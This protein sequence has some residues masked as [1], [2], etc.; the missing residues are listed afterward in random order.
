MSGVFRLAIVN[1]QDSSRE[2]LKHTLAELACVWLESECARY[3][4]F[5]EIV[6]QTR[7]D[8]IIVALDADPDRALRLVEEIG[9]LVSDASILVTSGTADGGLILRALRVGAKEFLTLPI[10]LP[11]FTNA[12]TRISDLD[13]G[14][15]GEKTQRSLTLAV[16]GSSGGVGATSLAVNLG[17]VLA[18]EQENEVALVDLDLALGDT[19]VFLDSMPDYTL[20][21]VALNVARLDLPLLKQSLTR[22]ESGVYLLPRPLAIQDAGIIDPDGLRRVIGLMKAAFSHVIL[23]LSKGYSALDMMALDAAD[24]VFLVTQLDLPGLRNTVR[25]LGCLGEIDGLVDK[26]KI[27]ANR[28]GRGDGQIGF[29]NAEENIGKEF[30][31]KLPNDYRSMIEMRNNGVP[32]IERSPR[33]ALTQEIVGLAMSLPGQSSAKRSKRSSLAS[34]WLSFWPSAERAPIED[35]S[36]LN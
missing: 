8:V 21:D 15:S 4:L 30:F 6:V 10:D 5:A 18:R 7:P 36:R 16:A 23:D 19:D 32:L 31:W 24:E 2:S 13:D 35:P 17:C 29:K 33:V 25:L 14:S 11:D 34:R 26:V 3:E 28:V 9:H 1:P 27:I 20:T 22:H 12:L